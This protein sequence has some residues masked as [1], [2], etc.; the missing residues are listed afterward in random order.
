[1]HEQCCS[2]ECLFFYSNPAFHVTELNFLLT[3][4]HLYLK[5][6]SYEIDF[7]NVDEN[8]QISA[9]MRATAGF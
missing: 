5:G 1:M 6:L 9:L 7:E 8:W 4:K 2:I 3:E